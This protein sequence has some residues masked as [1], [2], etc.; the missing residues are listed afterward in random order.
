M[1]VGGLNFRGVEPLFLRLGGGLLLLRFFERRLAGEFCLANAQ[2]IVRLGDG[3]VR[4][5]SGL[6]RLLTGEC[7]GRLG[8]GV[9]FSAIE[10]TG[11]VAPGCTTGDTTLIGVPAAAAESV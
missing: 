5:K 11:V 1:G 9:S 6:L 10:V 2:C 3:L 7:L 4:V 8:F